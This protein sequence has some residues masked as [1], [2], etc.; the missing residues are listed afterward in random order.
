M[1]TDKITI[2]AMSLKGLKSIEAIIEEFGPEIIDMVITAE[3]KNVQK[4]YYKEIKELCDANNISVRLNNNDTIHPILTEYTFAIGWKWMLKIP[5][6]KIIVLHDSLLPQYRGFAPLVT[7]LMNGDTTLGVTAFIANDKP[8][9]GSEICQSS[10]NISYPITIKE[11]TEEIIICYTEIML[12]IVGWIDR[13]A[14]IPSYP[15]NEDFAT[16]SI[17]LDKEDYKIDWDHYAEYIRLFIDAVGFPY[18]GARTNAKDWE[19]I[20]LEAEEL[21]EN[22]K[23][24]N[25]ARHIGKVLRLE[26]GCPVVICGDGL[27][28]ITKMEN[29]LRTNALP[30]HNLKTRFE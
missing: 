9:E 1:I 17:W 30:M 28:K 24:E 19:Y 16:Y 4:D 2:C 6:G 14:V 7:A 23:I 22:P 15:T 11:V 20:V 3:D 25:R 8:D 29:L 18:Q 13:G 27:L 12:Q 10:I 5:A 21:N 26:D